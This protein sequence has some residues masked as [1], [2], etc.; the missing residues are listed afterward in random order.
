[1]ASD[2]H[3]HNKNFKQLQQNTKLLILVVTMT[4]SSI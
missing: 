2:Q 4:K 3:V 1:M